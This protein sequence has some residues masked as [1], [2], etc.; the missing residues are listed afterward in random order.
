MA[1]SRKNRKSQ[2]P[3]LFN[4]LFWLIGAGGIFIA[5]LSLFSFPI[6][7]HLLLA[8]NIATFLL[9]GF[10]KLFALFNVRRVPEK[11]L[12]LTAF[13]GGAGGALL[14]MYIFRHKISKRS[15]QFYLAI[16]IF[17]EITIVMS[18]VYRLE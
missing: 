8:L 15:F 17:I 5:S 16:V 14:G 18:A 3:S 4:F 1:F 11:V 6:L 12:W 2:N 9:Y 7:L 13:L 10:D